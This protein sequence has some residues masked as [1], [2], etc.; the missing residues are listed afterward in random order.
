MKNIIDR[1]VEGGAKIAGYLAK[2][3]STRLAVA[4]LAALA[5]GGAW[6]GF[7]MTNP[8][9]GKEETYTYKFVGTTHIWNGT[10]YWQNSEGANPSAVPGVTDS[11]L[12][13]PI[14][15]DASVNSINIT[16][17][18][19]VEGWNL[20]MGLYKGA[21]VKLNNLQKLQG[22]NTPMW[23]TVDGTSQCTIGHMA[24]AKLVNSSPLSLYSAKMGGIAWSEALSDSSNGNGSSMPFHYYLTGTGS[25][26]FNAGISV[27]GN[28]AHVIKQA[29][30]TLTGTSQVSSKTLV[31]F[32]S[33]TKTFTADAAIKVYDTDGTTL[34]KLVGV[35]AV[36]QSGATIANTSSVLTPAD[37]V[38]TCEI[39][40]CTDGIVLYYVD[41]A[42]SAVTGYKP[43]I[44]IN[45]T[46]NGG[47]LTTTAD[48]GLAP[49]AV[50]G[51]VWN[52]YAVPADGA[53]STQTSVYSIDTTGTKSLVSGA[54]VSISG[55]RGS[56]TCSSLTAAS[57]LRH[58]YIDETATAGQNTPT[59][60]VSDIP[61]DHYT[62]VVYTAADT[63]NATFNYITVNGTDYTYVNEKLATGTSAWGNAGAAN[64]ANA[65]AEG[66]NVLVSPV[67]SGS[68]ATIVG[69]KASNT[70]R[71]NIAA[72]QIVGIGENDLVIELDGDKTHTFE[73][74]KTYD[75]VY[76]T[77]S[78]TLTFAGTASTATTLD[79]S[80]SAAVNM[81]GS[82]LTPSAV[83]GT[84]TVVYDG[85]Q[86]STTV[87]FNDSS[88]WHGTVWVKNIGSNG[89][90]SKVSTVLGTDTATATGNVLKDWG[91]ENSSVKFTNVRGWTGTAVCPWTLI[92]EDDSINYAWYNNNGYAA[93]ST[94]FAALKGS[95]TFYDKSV[96][97]KPCRQKIT[98]TDG[99][100]FTGAL[101][102]EG[103][104]VGLGGENTRGDAE[105]NNGTIEVVS[106]ATA[107]V[108]SGKTWTAGTGSIL[109]TGTLYANGTLAGTST[110]RAVR[111]SGMVVFT[112]S[113]PS[114][115]G[116]A[117]WKNAN[118]TGTVE[119]KNHNFNANIALGTYGNSGS[120]V[121]M[122]GSEAY[123]HVLNNPDHN[124]AELVI[125]AGGFT[126]DGTYSSG[127]VTFTLPFKVT[128]TGVYTL[129]AGGNA[130]KI[131]N[132]T[133]D[134]SEFA[135]YLSPTGANTRFVVGSTTRDFVAKSVVV[136]SGKVLSM[137]NF[138]AGPDGGLFIDEGG[139]VII[140]DSG[141]LWTTGGVTVDGTLTT[142]S[143]ANRIGGGTA[144]TLG[145]NGV[146]EITG[147]NANESTTEY[148]NISGTGSIKYSGSGY[149]VLS[150]NYP[151]D[152][153]LIDE[154]DAALVVPA[155][156]AT[157][158]SLSGTKGFR[159][160]WN[161][162][163]VEGRYLTIKQAK[164]TTWSGS[165]NQTADNRLTGVVVDSGTSTTGT[166][167]MS[168]TQT[169]TVTLAVNG[170]VNLTGTWKG[171]TTV[172]GTF[173]GTGTL[174][175]DLTF[176]A[177]AT[178]KAFASDT[179]GLAVSGTVTCPAE[180]KVTVD[181]SAL[182]QT[183]TKVLM[184]ASG[185]DDSQFALAS[186]QSGKL[187]VDGNALKVS[188]VT[189][190]AEY[191]DVPYETV[192]AAIN[193]AELAG[194]TYADVTILDPN[195][196]CPAGYYVDTE[197][198]NALTK[199]QA[200]YVL[201]DSTV[202]Y[203]KTAQLAVEGLEALVPGTSINFD[204]FEVYDGS[205]VAM[206]M[207]P[208]KTV[209][210]T[211]QKPFKVK[212]LNGA[213]VA[214]TINSVEFDLS[215]GDPDENDIVTYTKTN[216]ATTYVWVATSAQA[217]VRPS[218]WKVGSAEGAT[219]TRAPDATD[220]VVI[221]DGASLSGL[222]SSWNVAA[223]QVSGT[224]TFTGGG[225]L[226]S[227]SAI[228]LGANDSIVITG[229]LSPVPT[230]TV[231]N[232][233]VKTT[234][235]GST[236]TYAVAANPTVITAEEPV[237]QDYTNATLRATITVGG[238]FDAE[239]ATYT[240]TVGNQSY[241][242]K[243]ENGRVTFEI[244]GLAGASANVTITATPEGGSAAVATTDTSFVFGTATAWFE[245]TA[246]NFEKTGDWE[247]AEPSEGKI[248]LSGDANATFTPTKKM[249]GTTADVVWVVSF[250]APN[251]DDLSEE[252][253]GAQTAFRLAT[254]SGDAGYVFQLWAGNAWNNVAAAG[255][256]PATGVE[257][258]V[259]NHFDYS[260]HTLTASVNGVPLA[261]DNGTTTTF[262]LPSDT[263]KVNSFEFAGSGALTGIAGN[264]INT[265]LYVDGDGNAYATL[266][267]VPSGKPVTALDPS[268]ILTVEP[269]LELTVPA[270]M[271][272]ANIK[273]TYNGAS[274]AGYVNVSI[275]D[276]KVTLSAT[277][278][279]KP[280]ATA[281]TADRIAVGNVK[282]GL[283]YWVEASTKQNFTDNKTVGDPV[284]AT[285][286]EAVTVEP[287]NPTGK[288]IFY[289]VAV[290]A[291]KP[292]ATP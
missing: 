157:I 247:N 41:G 130:N 24:N 55:T 203:Y 18:L 228:T 100:Q 125:G 135:G 205:N 134:L 8:V 94:T 229:T 145:D 164:D 61:F 23:I 277:E 232:S 250:D 22:N 19:S 108:A 40:Q 54:T 217:Y 144:I 73:E 119:I 147:N 72:V 178:F 35:T 155:A 174:T 207:N 46:H 241:D 67:T 112:G 36:R 150:A 103:K 230:T 91:N 81:N 173:G 222:S 273:P 244:P 182:E 132:L 154:K 246:A 153:P 279:A 31:S 227:A 6:A 223:L 167:T 193:A 179:D 82:T 137:G 214:V 196:T 60:V 39:V 195:A 292:A 236:T 109:V 170:S 159:S 42:P 124:I 113:A 286:E 83:T 265:M 118:W 139:Q 186:G 284:Q 188:F 274:I 261:A 162:T 221:G 249:T 212:C 255:I 271:P 43:S 291:E 110:T 177:G 133:G 202:A 231:A 92:L 38:G 138:N 240:A 90:S 15:F 190:V 272:A 106:G 254:A 74:A 206:S 204:H 50:P 245:E 102:A 101:Y 258:T 70:C 184:T 117:W 201:T 180:S 75:T 64:S 176:N 191:N 105:D 282:P 269:G 259:T 84:G 256:T 276:G 85:A 27:T 288:V 128:G 65:L 58:G 66:V 208:A 280:S 226:T 126:Q 264:F 242:G 149:L 185:L 95:G 21:N 63:D 268:V 123:L 260:A 57:D 12:W 290:D 210:A 59:V 129:S 156:G 213:T 25:V 168:G 5:A 289:R 45:F 26:A 114:P 189:Y 99:S 224:V 194:G 89:E 121:C 171:N 160:D 220:T 211:Q 87:G 169:A 257:Y 140:L 13:D 253:V 235:A 79:I 192:Q 283:Y 56:H 243:Y 30:V 76:V 10:Q 136:G 47:N 148:N 200:A 131:V 175:G 2:T 34:K 1:I 163:P 225:T 234:T 262:A 16:A 161:D 266:A 49:Y 120:K 166:L 98:F 29:D 107:T 11:N 28:G 86:P 251:D 115:T 122:N 88:N 281:M 267:E 197:N 104:R 143:R 237:F 252:L 33:S 142:S 37:A 62:V 209:W 287:K 275:D 158:G 96:D 127:T 238:G 9:T 78:G 80:G 146:L 199:Y 216:K 278:A 233:Y 152:I 17:G 7:K 32:T 141:F 4:A 181:V 52:N 218:Y 248:A 285:S 69:H 183:G 3:V 151:T 20:R 53:T 219:A 51:T 116:D 239:H 14:L 165:I 48:V 68:T 71:G 215:V 97:N 93:R 111:G 187:S 77:G 263:T 270:G 198:S 172:S 44:N